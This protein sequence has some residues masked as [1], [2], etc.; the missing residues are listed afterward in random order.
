LQLTAG[1]SNIFNVYPSRQDPRY[2]E[3]GG[4]W[5]AVQMGFNGRSYFL[6]LRA[7]IATKDKK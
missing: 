1:S 5:D 4:A 3:S 6:K 2:T 7:N